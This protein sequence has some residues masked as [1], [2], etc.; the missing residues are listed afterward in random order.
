MSNPASSTIGP[1][2]TPPVV[3]REYDPRAAGAARLVAGLIR[4]QLPHLVVE[5]IGSTAVP[6]CAGQGIVD[7]LIPVPAGELETIQGALDRLGFQPPPARAPFPEERPMRVG[8]VELEGEPFLLH[9]HLV[10]ATSP[11]VDELRF[12]RTC[13]RA[14]AELLKAYVARKRQILAQGGTDPE[15]YRQEKAKFIQEVLG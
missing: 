11:E 12:F 1:Y 13:L 15:S 14:D 7:L 2:L 6:G 3:C 4:D 10:P 5:H 8:S 9:V